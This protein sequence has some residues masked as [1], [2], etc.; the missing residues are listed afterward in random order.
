VMVRRVRHRQPFVPLRSTVPDTERPPARR[1]LAAVTGAL[2]LSPDPPAP[3]G[4]A[5]IDRELYL[6]KE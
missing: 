2:A 4:V 6:P 1:P 3:E 5:L